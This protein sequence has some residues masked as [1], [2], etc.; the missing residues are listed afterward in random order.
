MCGEYCE[1]YGECD[2]CGDCEMYGDCM[3][4]MWFDKFE[5]MGCSYKTPSHPICYDDD[6]GD[7]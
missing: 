2:D 6:D 3:D 1:Y 5:P 4:C 7:D